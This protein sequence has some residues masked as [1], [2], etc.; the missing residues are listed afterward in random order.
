MQQIKRNQGFTLVELMVTI[1][2][3]VIIV[4]MAAPSFGNLIAK[5]RL[6]TTAKDL[7]YLFGQARSQSAVL[8]KEVTV[9]FTSGTNDANNFYWTPQYDDIKLTSDITDVVFQPIGLVTSRQKMIDNPAFKKEQPED[10]DTNPREIPKAVPLIFAVCSK[11]LNLSKE[12]NISKTG[13]IEKIE[14]KAGACS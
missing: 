14:E 1:A 12:I 6:N 7:G 2:V 9:K 4:M 8:R 11:K 5:Q 10:P 13:I 3:L